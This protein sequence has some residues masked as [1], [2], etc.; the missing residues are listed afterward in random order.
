MAIQ[1]EKTHLMNASMVHPTPNCWIAVWTY[2][3]QPRLHRVHQKIQSLCITGADSQDHTSLPPASTVLAMYDWSRPP[4]HITQTLPASPPASQCPCPAHLQWLRCS[5]RFARAGPW[6]RRGAEPLEQIVYG[7][8]NS[9]CQQKHGVFTA[10]D[11]VQTTILHTKEN[12]YQCQYKN[13]PTVRIL[14]QQTW[15]ISTGDNDVGKSFLFAK[16]RIGTFFSPWCDNM[17]SISS[18]ATTLIQQTDKCNKQ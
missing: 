8:K 4:D 15:A 11:G 9:Q 2:T 3:R 17:W 12:G 16:K 7:P 10:D 5:A 18:F 6:C 1:H 14:A 13:S